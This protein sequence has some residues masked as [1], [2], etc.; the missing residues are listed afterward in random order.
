MEYHP[1]EDCNDTG[2]I[3]ISPYAG[4]WRHVSGRV[5][6]TAKGERFEFTPEMRGVLI[7]KCTS[8]LALCA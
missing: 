2:E 7:I 6:I 3:E 8:C 5:W 4:G 1:C